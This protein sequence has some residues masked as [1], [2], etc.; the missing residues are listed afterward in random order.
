MGSKNKK[1]TEIGGKTLLP[2]PVEPIYEEGNLTDVLTH[3]NLFSAKDCAQIIKEH[4]P[5]KWGESIID[6]PETGD[7][8]RQCKNWA[9]DSTSEEGL[10]IYNR[11]MQV[12]AAAN[13]MNYHFALDYVVEVQLTKYE[14][15]DFHKIH[16][17]CGA[18]E[19]GN[20]KLSCIVNL[21]S[22]LERIGG[23]LIIPIGNFTA[24]REVGG[25]TIFPSYIASEVTPVTK[26]TLYQLVAWVGG[27]HRFK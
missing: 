17:D 3:L 10:G 16:F 27:I 12:V 15:G 23:D 13:D 6:H 4:S 25:V 9:I 5:E 26:G 24:T 8:L 21:S 19:F 22:T 18:N 1:I 20:R 7:R 2:K 11:V 14:A